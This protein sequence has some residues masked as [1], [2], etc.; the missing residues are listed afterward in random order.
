RV[1]SLLYTETEDRP[2]RFNNVGGDIVS[3]TG[4]WFKE[5]PDEYLL[6][7]KLAL[8]EDNPSIRAAACKAIGKIGT[9]EVVQILID[10][11]GTETDP[12]VIAAAAQALAALGE[13]T[14]FYDHGVREVSAEVMTA[15]KPAI[16]HV[17]AFNFRVGVTFVDSTMPES[18]KTFVSKHYRQGSWVIWDDAANNTYRKDYENPFLR[19]WYKSDDMNLAMLGDVEITCP[20][21]GTTDLGDL[22]TTEAS[23]LHQIMQ[24]EPEGFVTTFKMGGDTYK[25]HQVKGGVEVWKKDAAEAV[26]RARYLEANDYAKEDLGAGDSA[27]FAALGRNKKLSTT[28]LITRI[29]DG[30]LWIQGNEHDTLLANLESFSGNVQVKY[31][32]LIGAGVEIRFFK[33]LNTLAF[34]DGN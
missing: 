3:V 25:V 5:I 6:P 29:N 9:P 31:Q 18:F 27:K 15:I 4:N 28:E 24:N 2:L 23:A 16:L 17:A 11:I 13:T 12:A 10:F 26:T 8:E 30:D 7:L 21:T 22:I 20:P 32:D 14:L 33:D 19:V 34:R 1:Q